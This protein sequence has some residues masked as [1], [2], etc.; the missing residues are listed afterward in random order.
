MPAIHV[1][2]SIMCGR[3]DELGAELRELEAA[4][5][6]SVHI[7]IMDGHFVPNFTFGPDVVAAINDATTMP[8]HAHMMVSDPG[9]YVRPFADA[10]ADV[11]LFHIEST[12]YPLRLIEQVTEAG[13]VAGI[14]VNPSTPLSFLQDV[15]APYIL[16]M[17]VE[18]GFAGQRWTPATEDRLKRVRDLVADN[19]VIG[20]DGN[21]TLDRVAGT[22]P[23]GV[24]MFV[25]GTSALF[26]GE[27]SYS[28]AVAAVRAAGAACLT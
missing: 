26:T 14:A 13:M 19:V 16:V 7:D 27:R 23:L 9:A 3:L 18:P 28:K 21:V 5:V 20:I 4:G 11:Y 10:G 8:L 22:T 6:D 25:C 15:Q 24:S 17:S 1:S 2:A 12:R